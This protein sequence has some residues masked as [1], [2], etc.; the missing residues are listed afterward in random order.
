MMFYV[1]MTTVSEISNIDFEIVYSGGN[2]A[3]FF[4]AFAKLRKAIISFVMSVCPS[5][6]MEQL[7]FHWTDFHE[8]WYLNF[9]KIFRENSS[10][11]NIVQ[12]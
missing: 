8:I 3:T 4:S 6:R 5:V 2:L 11:I 12:E 1:G 7:G 9:F 10:F